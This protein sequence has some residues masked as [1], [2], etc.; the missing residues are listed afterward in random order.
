ME[1]NKQNILVA[2]RMIFR[3]VA[4]ILLLAGITWKE[5][6]EVCKATLVEVASAEF[7][8]KGRPTNA[9]RVAILTGFTRK[10]VSRLRNILEAEDV[11]SGERMNH[12]TRVLTGWYT[13]T[14]FLDADGSPRALAND[15]EGA[16]FP[17][18]CRRYASDVPATAMLKELKHV[19]AVTDGPN[20][21]LIVQT[22]YY[23]P[24]QLDAERV[25]SSGS[26]MEDLGNTVAH[27][28]YREESDLPRFERRAHNTCVPESVKPQFQAYLEEEGQ[29]FLERVDQWLTDNEIE[30]S[31]TEKGIRLGLG[32]YWIEQEM[33]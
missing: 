1:Q 19:G 13:D 18:L 20:G 31:S 7:G 27:N 11:Y 17:A 26:V 15:G 14:E 12:A 16:S 32:A 33:D 25:L 4:K 6:A 29:E 8:I 5:I 21:R 10:E 24:R 2:L 3:P 28:L 9:S 30:A 22:R 23:M